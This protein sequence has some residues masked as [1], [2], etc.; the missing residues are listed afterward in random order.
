MKRAF[1]MWKGKQS[2]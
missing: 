2:H 1:D